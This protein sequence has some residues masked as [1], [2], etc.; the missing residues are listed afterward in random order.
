MVGIGSYVGISTKI[1]D[2]ELLRLGINAAVGSNIVVMGGEQAGRVE[3]HSI[4]NKDT[5]MI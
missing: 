1:A 4:L 5:E 2:Y 3:Q